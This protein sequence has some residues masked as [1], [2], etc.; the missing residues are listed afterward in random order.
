MFENR[1]IQWTEQNFPKGGKESNLSQLLQ[2]CVSKFKDEESYKNDERYLKLWLKFV[3]KT[4]AVFIFV[5][6]F[7]LKSL[8]QP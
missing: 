1:Y 6:I 3:S 2:Q 5:N 8:S 4:T 7:L